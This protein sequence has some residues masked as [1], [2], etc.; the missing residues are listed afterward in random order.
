[1]ADKPAAVAKASDFTAR[2]GTSYLPEYAGQLKGR[3]KRVLSDL[4]GLTQFGVNLL[5]LAPGS[6]SSHRH[7]HEAEDEFIYVLE[8]EVTLIDDQ[9]EHRM[10]PG[11]CAGFKAGVPNGHHL[12][13]KSDK[14]AVCLELGTRAKDEVIEYSEADMR[15]IKANGGPIQFTRRDGSTP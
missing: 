12:V 3:E 6:W 9:G 1:M 15:A 5:T 8:G 10:T 14:P 4:F 11:M 7:W 13:N 2:T